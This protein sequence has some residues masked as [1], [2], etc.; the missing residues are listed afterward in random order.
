M[1]AKCASS[2]DFGNKGLL[3]SGIDYTH[4]SCPESLSN[5]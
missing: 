4:R 1:F 2:G 3:E 5:L